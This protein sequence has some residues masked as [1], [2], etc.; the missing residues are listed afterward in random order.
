MGSLW[1]IGDILSKAIVGGTSVSSFIFFLLS[2]MR[3]TALCCYNADLPRAQ[4]DR[5][6]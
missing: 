2:I 4:N 5:V 1:A 3:L 6:N